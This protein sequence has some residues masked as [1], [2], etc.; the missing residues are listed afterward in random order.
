MIIFFSQENP[1]LNYIDVV[2]CLYIKGE[3]NYIGPQSTTWLIVP[4]ELHVSGALK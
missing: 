1:L 4:F 3:V 2:L